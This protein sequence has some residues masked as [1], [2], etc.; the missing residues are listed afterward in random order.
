MYCRLQTLARDGGVEL[1]GLQERG[2]ESPQLRVTSG[3][4][5]QRILGRQIAQRRDRVAR[6][7]QPV[8]ADLLV[9][10]VERIAILLTGAHHRVDGAAKQADQTANL[11]L[12]GRPRLVPRPARTREQLRGEALEQSDRGIGQCRL[13]L[14]ELCGQGRDPPALAEVVEQG[15]RRNRTLTCELGQPDRVDD[16]AQ[17][18]R[19]PD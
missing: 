14:R 16:R 6:R 12:A 15:Q 18:P 7:E 2:R 4:Q 11:R 19:Q 1:E 13:Q 5:R 17:I 10:H 8:P 9:E 3:R